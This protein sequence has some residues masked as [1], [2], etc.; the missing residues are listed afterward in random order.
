MLPETQ[1]SYL[2]FVS[3]AGRR[4]GCAA[5][6][7]RWT[8]AEC[9]LP[10]PGTQSLTALGVG[11]GQR[12]GCAAAGSG[13]RTP[14]ASCPSSGTQYLTA[15]GVGGGQRRGCAA[16]GTSGRTPS[17]S[18][19]SSEMQSLTALGVGGGQRRG[20]AAAGTGGRT[21]SASCPSS[22]ARSCAAP[23]ASAPP[24][25]RRVLDSHVLPLPALLVSGKPASPQSPVYTCLQ[26]APLAVNAISGLLCSNPGIFRSMA[27][28][29]RGALPALHQPR[30]S[31]LGSAPV[32]APKK[33]LSDP[34]A[35]QIT[36]QADPLLVPVKL[37]NL[38]KP[39]GLQP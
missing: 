8:H 39:P 16:A 15:L 29:F 26:C 20:C 13:G 12:R 1:V 28:S 18:C 37:L 9:F 11:A 22:C 6:E 24:A 36:V 19:P 3:G 32:A 2:L 7:N 5:A 21:P 17:A 14:S 23:L 4:R 27:W 34:S 38:L 33:N 31:V 35:E 30:V 25:C 10:Q